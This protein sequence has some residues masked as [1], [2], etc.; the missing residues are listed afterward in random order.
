M[1][2]VLI[3]A[4]ICGYAL[5]AS[6]QLCTQWSQ[7]QKVGELDTDML[8]EASGLVVSRQFP[9]RIYHHNDS[10]DAAVFYVTDLKGANTVRVPYATSGVLDV[11]DIAIGP[12]ES[13]QCIF[14]GDIGDNY[15]ERQTV[16]IWMVPETLDF[17]NAM[18]GAKKITLRYPDGPHNAESLAVHPITGDV[19]ILTKEDK[20]RNKKTAPARLFRLPKASLSKSSE[21]LQFIGE[22]DLW[23]VAH[24]T[25][26]YGA[27]ATSMD[28]S[29]D[30][31]RLLIL[32]YES[33]LEIKLEKVIGM[34]L[35]S[36]KWVEGVDYRLLD[37]HGFLSQQ[38]GIG[39][40]P[41]GNSF[42][43]DSEF[44]PKE[45]DK[46]SPLYKVDCLQR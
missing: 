40:T 45:G 41:D 32:T 16:E 37:L 11:E 5:T 38:E 31:K 39:Y 15:R 23:S 10:G 26:M 24:A 30:G 9:N 44:K 35:I 34:P 14:L 28:I 7:P 13:G 3:A 8:H 42:Y 36:Q 46:N 20:H 25:D 17:S 4:A 22:I 21:T 33:A 27:I 1:F 12:C 29:A 2:R 43:F 18:S 6:A 19:Y